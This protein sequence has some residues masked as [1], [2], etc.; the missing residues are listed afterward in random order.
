MV[1]NIVELGKEKENSSQA[2]TDVKARRVKNSIQ[3]K[4]NRV[5]KN[6]VSMNDKTSNNEEIIKSGK[7]NH[8]AGYCN[9]ASRK[10]VPKTS[11]HSNFQKRVQLESPML[12]I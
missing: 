2:R 7:P 10:F 1:S 3:Q 5:N 6:S 4:E 9:G 12:T 11:H 8:S